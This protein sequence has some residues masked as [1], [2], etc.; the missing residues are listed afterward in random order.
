MERFVILLFTLLSIYVY[1]MITSTNTVD[2]VD[3][4]SP[5]AQEKYALKNNSQRKKRPTMLH[6]YL[7]IN[8]TDRD[9]YIQNMTSHGLMITSMNDTN[10]QD[11]LVQSTLNQLRGS[12]TVVQGGITLQNKTNT[13]DSS[14]QDIIHQRKRRS[15]ELCS[16]DATNNY[17]TVVYP[18]P[19]DYERRVVERAHAQG[20]L[21]IDGTP[22]VYFIRK[23][24]TNNWIVFVPGGAWCSSN[25]T[26]FWRSKTNL[27][28]TKYL[29]NIATQ[30]GILSSSPNKNP[31][32]YN[33]NILYLQYCDG[34][35]FLGNSDDPVEFKNT[36]LYSRGK[37]ILSAFLE[38][39]IGRYIKLNVTKKVLV[40]G[41]SAGGLAVM[42][43]A[44]Y[45][46][47]QLPKGIQVD[48]VSDA[49]VFID[50]T[51]IDNSRVYRRW[52]RSL[53]T[54][55]NIS[56]NDLLGECLQNV[57]KNKPWMCIMPEHSLPHIKVNLTIINSLLDAWQLLRHMGANCGYHPTRLNKEDLKK[58]QQLQKSMLKVLRPLTRKSNMNFFLYSCVQ[59]CSIPDNK[60]WN[61][62]SVSNTTLQDFI[63]QTINGNRN[64]YIGSN[65][66]FQSISCV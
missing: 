53:Y 6:E 54:Y 15:K 49:G 19:M 38:E 11:Q 66:N 3:H 33:W 51:C 61:S 10:A 59:H 43:N 57:S 12:S 25:E 2:K 18:K 58:A 47:S 55:H 46:A 31:H 56:T 48:F 8:S 17:H 13:K 1:L 5:S 37:R 62:I 45:I 39:I 50:V 32:F 27:G 24:K 16:A 65:I 36:R 60:S 21:C 44:H 4:S 28:S 30:G 52:T 40:V 23:A 29:P 64:S 14:T 22:P 7:E 63:Y 42:L 20:A 34:S 26:C 35:S 41:N 9:P